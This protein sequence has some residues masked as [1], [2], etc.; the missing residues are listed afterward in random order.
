MKNI[1]IFYKKQ[2]EYV[3]EKLD[4]LDSIII[5]ENDYEKYSDED[6][7]LV[8]NL[9]HICTLVDKATQSQITND[10]VT[11]SREVNMGFAKIETII[12]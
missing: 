2:R 11:I 3:D 7:N 9:M 10:K 8:D 12:L 5:S 1:P 6:K 4:T